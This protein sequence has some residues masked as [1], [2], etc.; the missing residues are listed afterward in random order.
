MVGT[1]M[2]WIF[3]Y[4][5]LLPTLLGS[6]AHASS[7]HAVLG[8]DWD[9]L[10]NRASHGDYWLTTSFVPEVL[11][12][13]LVR[14]A[15]VFKDI[16]RKQWYLEATLIAVV[17]VLLMMVLT[18]ILAC[19]YRRHLIVRSRKSQLLSEISTKEII[20]ERQLL[21]SLHDIV[22]RPSAIYVYV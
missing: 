15:S 19:V 22:H 12:P 14:I 20:W 21:S 13:V 8:I 3:W 10:K 1:H 2:K 11:S 18:M 4:S 6:P 7:L 17:T 16:I 9:S 5:V